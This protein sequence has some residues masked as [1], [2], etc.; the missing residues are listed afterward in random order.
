MGRG[1]VAIIL[2]ATCVLCGPATSAP[3]LTIG[4]TA[5]PAGSTGVECGTELFVQLTS[6]AGTPYS[7][8]TGGGTITG[9]QVNTTGGVPGVPA[10]FVVLRKTGTQ[11]L[12]VG[13]S[14]NNLPNPLP[15]GGIASFGITPPMA[16]HGGDTLGLYTAEGGL[17]CFYKLGATPASDT[18]FS[19]APSG[20]P[21]AGQTLSVLEPESPA[22]YT[23]NEAAS[24]VP[25]GQD[26]AV[27]TAANPASATVGNLAVLSS[28]VTNNGSATTPIEFVDNV[29]PGLLISGVAGESGACS[30]STQRVT[31]RFAELPVQ[32]SATV[33]VTV[34]PNSAGSYVNTVTVATERGV[35]DP[36]PANNSATATLT[37]APAV[38]PLQLRC[39]VPRLAGTPLAVAKKVLGLLG[40]SVGKVAKAHSK[41]LAK[42]TVLRTSPGPGAFAPG[43]VVRITESSG[44]SRHGKGRRRNGKR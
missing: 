6:Y 18:L 11:Y 12:V 38:A 23:M 16:V 36:L 41:K 43:A 7:V 27:A 35:P 37:V 26:A 31:C 17:K 29:P 20:V 8:P 21:A 13:T 34:V 28:T 30:V 10:T 32:H 1:L 14:T 25:L 42:G 15:P 33:L 39:L 40:C 24:F 3:A 4:S 2:T 9:W 19:L 22:G 44:P 5:Q